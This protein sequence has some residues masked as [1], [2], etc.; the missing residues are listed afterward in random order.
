MNGFLLCEALDMQIKGW[1]AKSVFVDMRK[2]EMNNLKEL[3]REAHR[4][5]ERR[6]F[7]KMLLSGRIDPYLYYQ[8]LT[9]QYSNYVVL[10]SAVRVPIY[11]RG[12]FRAKYILNDMQELEQEYGYSWNPYVIRKSTTEYVDYIYQMSKDETNNY[13]LLAHVYVRHFGDMFGGSIIQSRVPGSGSMYDF[14]HKEQL[15]ADMRKLLRDDMAGE[16]N[17]CFDFA[18]RLFE[19]LSDEQYD[20]GPLADAARGIP[21][22]PK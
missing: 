8:Y 4:R 3:T 21:N 10:E 20:L 15:I 11:V 2:V 22:T 12:I 13:R 7:A 14:D 16:A 19:E 17:V 18:T 9:N 6:P 5:A 1:G